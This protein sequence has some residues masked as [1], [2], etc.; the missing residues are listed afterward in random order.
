MP[1]EIREL[2]IK[3]YVDNSNEG[4]GPLSPAI[5]PEKEL[6]QESINEHLDQLLEIIKD[7][8]ER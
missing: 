6:L 3:A 1:V 7:Q 2:I 5:S 4:Q 8:K